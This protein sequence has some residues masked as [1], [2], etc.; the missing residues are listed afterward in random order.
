MRSTKVLLFCLCLLIAAIPAAFGQAEV[1]SAATTIGGTVNVT[2]TI[3]V[4]T[5]SLTNFTCIAAV[6]VLEVSASGELQ[7]QEGNTVA[8]TGS[9]ST[10][11][12]KLSI[13]YS[14]SLATPTS[15]TMMTSYTVLASTGANGLPQR[16]SGRTPLDSRKVP[17]NGLTTA[18]TAAVTQ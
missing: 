16:T 14:W 9:G 11:T 1:S 5:T 8:A 17:A 18:L 7:F 13:P 3:T 10:R 15:D 2:I 6:S 12:C 4:K